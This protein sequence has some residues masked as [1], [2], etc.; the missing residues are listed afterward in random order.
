MRHDR[1]TFLMAAGSAGALAAFP[2]AALALRES[3]D[4]VVPV[5]PS[6]VAMRGAEHLVYELHLTNFSADGL[7]PRRLQVLDREHGAVLAEFAAEALAARMALVRPSGD[8][9]TAIAPGRR[10]V[11]YVELS[12]P[13]GKVP[14]GLSHR[15]EYAMAGTGQTGRIEGAA[16]AIGAPAVT[17]GPPLAG[18]PWV[19]VYSADWPRGH[20]RVMYAIDGRARIPGRFAID[21][22]KVDDNGRTVARGDADLPASHLGHGAPV[23]AVADATVAAVRDDMTEKATVSGNHGHGLA[24]ASGNFV[25]LELARGRFAFYE[26]LKPGSVKVRA[27]EAV[28]RG[29]ILAALGFTGDST[30]PHLHFH[31]ADAAS[32]LGGEGM[33]FAIDRFELLGRYDDVGTLG[34]ARWS[35]RP[36]TLMAERRN[37]RPG[38]NDVIRFDA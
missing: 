29:G 37:E 10:A 4:V 36:D 26:H 25:A 18:G 8:Q 31:V 33:P 35:E 22:V 2:T 34:K 13:V 1:R 14:A 3:F 23:I 19:A 30:G 17:V 21:W 5:G 12:L 11:V 38:P 20:R 9:R 27:G 15:L 6:P 7:S 16:I 24:D 28:R 32:P